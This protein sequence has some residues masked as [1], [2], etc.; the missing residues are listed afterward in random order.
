MKRMKTFLIYAL[1]IVALWIFSD[2]VIYLTINGTYKQKDAKIYVNTPQITISE[3]KA[4][5]VN[6]VVKGSIK[7]N[8]EET[9]NNTYLKIDMYSKR[10]VNL[11]TKY[12]KINNLQKGELQEFEMGYK[13]TDVDYVT[14]STTNNVE[15]ATLDQFE[16][17]ELTF[18]ALIGTLMF[19]YLI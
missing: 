7:N 18:Y 8:S 12:V 1:A 6:G 10:D 3:N 13:F 11:G 5:Y 2:I 15:N 9:I 16:S 19:I 4:T 17:Q 14:I